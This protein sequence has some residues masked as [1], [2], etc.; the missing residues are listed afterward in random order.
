M[1]AKFAYDLTLSI[2]K[3]SHRHVNRVKTILYFTGLCVR[4]TV[5]GTCSSVFAGVSIC[6]FW[7]YFLVTCSYCMFL[8]YICF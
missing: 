5:T 1:K 6:I 7:V 2:L 4:S 3:A 8:Q